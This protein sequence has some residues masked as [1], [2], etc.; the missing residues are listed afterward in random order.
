[1]VCRISCF[2]F[3]FSCCVDVDPI[4]LAP[5]PLDR[6]VVNSTGNSWNRYFPL[7]MLS[8][9]A[10]S[11][12]SCIRDDGDSRDNRGGI[13]DG[14]AIRSAPQEKQQG[15]AQSRRA[16]NASPRMLWCSFQ[17]F[18]SFNIDPV[19]VV[20]ELGCAFDEGFAGAFGIARAQPGNNLRVLLSGSDEFV[21]GR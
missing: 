11:V 5:E 12:G 4:I 16:A 9:L 15:P 2:S 19:I 7:S 10:G 18:R 1:M 3:Q 21:A 20:P 13:D 8:V 6:E 17:F 14:P